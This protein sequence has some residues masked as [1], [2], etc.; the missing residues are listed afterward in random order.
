MFGLAVDCLIHCLVLGSLCNPV[1]NADAMHS[2]PA[3]DFD[4]FYGLDLPMLSVDLIK[5]PRVRKAVVPD[6]INDLD[7]LHIILAVFTC[8]HR[9]YGSSSYTVLEQLC[10]LISLLPLPEFAH[11]SAFSA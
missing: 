10:E 9:L 7:C 6:L 2:K 4:S 11:P 1:M 8:H 5:R 3:K